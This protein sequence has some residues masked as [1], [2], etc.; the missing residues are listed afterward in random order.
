MKTM[1]PFWTVFLA[2]L[3]ALSDFGNGLSLHAIR[4]VHLASMRGWSNKRLLRDVNNYRRL[5]N[6]LPTTKTKLTN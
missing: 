6:D 4:E 5:T 2:D 1:S 3:R